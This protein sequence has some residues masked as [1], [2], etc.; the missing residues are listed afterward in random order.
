M[1]R[2]SVPILILL[3][4]LFAGVVWLLAVY[5]DLP[6]M[7]G[8]PPAETAPSVSEQQSPTTADERTQAEAARTDGQASFDV[9][10]IDPEGTSVFAGRAEP[11]ATVTIMGDGKA[12]GTTEADE[13]GEWTFA[14]EHPFASADPKLALSV[15]SA[16][17]AKTDK[18]AETKV[19][20]SLESREA[21]KEASK[22]QS[23]GTPASDLLKSFEGIVAAARDEAEQEKKDG[24]KE[25]A[26]AATQ[27]NAEATSEV[28]P[29]EVEPSEAKTEET[30]KEKAEDTTAPASTDQKPEDK[31][32]V[33][34]PPQA[35]QASPPAPS[36]P[37]KSDTLPE[38][39]ASPS[40]VAPPARLAAT[41]PEPPTPRKSIPVP[42][43]FIYNEA[44]FT[45][46]GRKAV[47]LLLEYLQLKRYPGVSLT[48]HAD[49]RGS[50][51]FNMELSR[52][53]LDAVAQLLKDGGYKGELELIPKGE[54]E[55]FAGV[56]RSQYS[57]DDLYQ[58]D[59]RV[60]LIIAP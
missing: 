44:N 2:L 31:V 47:S 37:A 54:T 16:A 9:A 57:Q 59:R 30:T 42:I 24:A 39:S 60:E 41:T 40:S 13:N 6:Q 52:E 26:K 1:T 56:V 14:T 21:A 23:A 25:A 36:T 55:P 50:H 29:S 17:E 48:G 5:L 8:K 28:K 15:K 12:V 35:P 22:A 58:F 51:E 49:E 53:R 19:A 3:L 43:T 7:A 33:A 34:E 46:D 18:A 4:M 10:R 11:G 32:A 20:G 27:G 45:E 38:P